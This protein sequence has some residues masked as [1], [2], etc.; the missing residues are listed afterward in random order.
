MIKR[1]FLKCPGCNISFIARIGVSTAK[2]TRFYL[3]CPNCSLPIKG[4]M[5]GED[6][7][8]Y[9]FNIECEEVPENNLPEKPQIITI[10]PFVPSRYNADSFDNLGAFPTMTL[11]KL[12]GSEKMINFET[13]YS[14]G[15]HISKIIWPEANKI[16]N[17]YIMQN[18]PMFENSIRANLD[19][20]NIGSKMHERTNIAYNYLHA[21]TLQLIGSSDIGTFYMIE[22]FLRKHKAAF[23]NYQYISLIRNEEPKI[24]SLE[25]NLFNTI[26]NF[27]REYEVWSMGRLNHHISENAKNNL[28][29]LILFRDEFSTV[30]DLYQQGFEIA[31]KCLWILVSTQNSLKHGDPNDFGDKHP[32]NIP[33]SRRATSINK[34]NKLPNAHKI[35]YVSMVP[36]WEVIGTVLDNKRRNTIGHATVHHDLTDGRIYSDTDTQGTTYMQFLGEIFDIFTLL[37]EF[38]QIVRSARIITSPDFHI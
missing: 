29:E 21:T 30:R 9:R 11:V 28:N 32:N 19:L 17:Y 37:S 15:Q 2:N 20:D 35:S 33:R 26:D 24:L 3:P 1:S 22:R 14:R 31:C 34:F 4:S 7:M 13:E 5:D 12:L 23:K 16:F 38:M 6:I 36:G 8:D 10:D 27:M 18:W 25:K